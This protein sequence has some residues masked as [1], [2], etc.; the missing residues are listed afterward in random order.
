MLEIPEEELHECKIKD[1]AEKFKVL[2]NTFRGLGKDKEEKRGRAQQVKG[3]EGLTCFK[4]QKVG[5]FSKECKTPRSQLKCSYCKTEG[6]HVTN[7]FCKRYIERKKTEENKT[8]EKAKAN[9]VD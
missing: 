6:R 3:K 9:K 7:D 2:K 5:H 8:G 1:T 4:C